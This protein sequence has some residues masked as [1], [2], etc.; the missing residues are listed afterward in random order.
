M[1]TADC[2]IYDTIIYNNIKIVLFYS[3]P[4]LERQINR[5]GYRVGGWWFMVVALWRRW[6]WRIVIFMIQLFIII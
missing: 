4:P 2:N 3:P 6:R 5:V 1:A